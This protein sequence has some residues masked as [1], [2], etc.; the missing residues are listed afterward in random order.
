LV[1]QKS[2]VRLPSSELIVSTAAID[3]LRE[4]LTA[5]GWERF[6]VPTFKERFGLSR[7]WAIPLLEHLDSI[8]AT[9]RLG[10]ERLVIRRS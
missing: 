3:T 2:L 10:N 7:K 1:E 6:T 4:E 9:R 8:G 5:T